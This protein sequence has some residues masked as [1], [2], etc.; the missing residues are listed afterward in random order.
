MHE[1]I[2]T[3]G[4]T[5]NSQQTHRNISV[6]WLVKASEY[7]QSI[8]SH[9]HIA[10]NIQKLRQKEKQKTESCDFF[11]QDFAIWNYL[12]YTQHHVGLEYAMIMWNQHN[13]N[14]N[15]KNLLNVWR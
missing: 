7:V 10:Q 4:K 5:T 13:N 1:M 3:R 6:Y 11:D 14:N 15:S 9:A 8:R 2:T 12:W